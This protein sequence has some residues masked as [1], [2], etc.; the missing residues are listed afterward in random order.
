[1][2]DNNIYDWD[3]GHFYELD[4]VTI[5]QLLQKAMKPDSKEAF[6]TQLEAYLDFK[7]PSNYTPHVTNFKPFHRA[8]LTYRTHFKQL[9]D[10]M[11]Y[12]NKRNVPDCHNK[13]GGLIKIFV[14]Q[15]VPSGYAEKVVRSWKKQSFKHV[16][17]FLDLFYKQV[18]HSY[19]VYLKAKDA[20]YL[21]DEPT[22][23]TVSKA[24]I[25][26]GGSSITPRKPSSGYNDRS[27][28]EDKHTL[29]GRVNAL[30]AQLED[31]DDE[32]GYEEEIE[33]GW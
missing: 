28:G 33:V 6:R 5:V 4:T 12:D 32:E 7:L 24:N 18:Q 21:F 10:Y 27:K 15:I 22:P 30:S 23:Y 2:A 3:Y 19:D 16:D 20:S 11:S 1:M 9:Y 31:S 29:T 8:L 25:S 14:S 13:P 17:D 26:M